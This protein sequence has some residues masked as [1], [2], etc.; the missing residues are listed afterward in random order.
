[1]VG[2][3]DYDKQLNIVFKKKNIQLLSYFAFQVPFFSKSSQF[4]VVRVLNDHQNNIAVDEVEYT[5]EELS[6]FVAFS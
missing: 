6:G 5:V 2:I 4:G 1:M 3:A